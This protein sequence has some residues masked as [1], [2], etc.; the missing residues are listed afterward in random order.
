MVTEP[1]NGAMFQLIRCILGLGLLGL[2]AA[3]AFAA[4]TCP[5]TV[6]AALG[7]DVRG[8]QPFQQVSE[9]Q[10]HRCTVQLKNGFTFPDPA[11]TPGAIN[12]TVTIDVLLDP[13][14]HTGC[15]RDRA[16]SAGDKDQTYDAYSIMKPAHDQGADM[17]CEKDHFVPLELGGADTLDNIWP[18]CGPDGVTLSRRYF[19]QKDMVE[20]YLAAMVKAGK[21]GLAA[22]QRLI[23]SDWSQFLGRARQVCH[24][25][26]RGFVCDVSGESLLAQ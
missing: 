19:K 7:I 18:Q 6:A 4:S 3:H 20:S 24:N 1:G 15:L 5:S 17:T 9:N 2:A 11:C 16:T 8:D 14:F 25:S 23:V 12:P 13:R 10:D 21:G 22:A 26:P